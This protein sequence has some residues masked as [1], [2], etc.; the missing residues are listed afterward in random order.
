VQVW[1]ETQR[2][3]DLL[4]T[5]DLMA[6]RGRIVVMAGR[7]AQPVFPVGPFYV[8]CLS[9]FGFAMFNM[10]PDDQRQCSEKI[11]RWLLDGSLKAQIGQ[12]LK[13]SQTAEAH[14]LQEAN[15]LQKAGTLSGKIVLTV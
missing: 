10:P 12:R 7:T 3:P 6:P 15:T 8:K 5:V 1:Y 9:M 2:E 13:L 14:Q 11:N 4:R